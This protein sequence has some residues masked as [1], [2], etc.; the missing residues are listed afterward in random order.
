MPCTFL[1]LVAER[2]HR[3]ERAVVIRVADQEQRPAFL[4]GQDVALGVERH[5]DQRAGLL[6]GHQ[7]LDGE[8]GI[9]HEP[10]AFVAMTTSSPH[11]S[12]PPSGP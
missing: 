5:R 12:T 2:L 8:L 4:R 6:V 3:F 11:G 10:R 9:D 7:P 1:S